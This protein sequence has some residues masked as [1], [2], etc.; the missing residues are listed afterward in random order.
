[1]KL[2]TTSSVYMDPSK[3]RDV[4]QPSS[5]SPQSEVKCK[6]EEQ[7]TDDLAS[8]ISLPVLNFTP[9]MSHHMNPFTQGGWSRA[10]NGHSNGVSPWDNTADSPPSIFGALPT[11]STTAP[12]AMQPDSVTYRFTG[13]NT[14][15]L[16]CSVLGP[17]ERVAYRVVT[18]STAPSCTIFKDNESRNIAMVQWQPNATLEIRGVTPRRKV[19]EWL[20][21]SS[22][23]TYV[24]NSFTYPFKD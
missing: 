10:G 20:R 21:L 1:M 15:V 23:R 13:F 24:F 8:A 7:S 14:T 18:D 22:D 2:E 9:E 4:L 16:N 19:R 5:S 11:M 6:V 12:R 3:D 17:Q